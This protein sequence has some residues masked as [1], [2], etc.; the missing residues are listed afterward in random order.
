MANNASLPYMVTVLNH[1]KQGQFTTILTIY[2]DCQNMVSIVNYRNSRK[3]SQQKARYQ[4]TKIFN[5]LAL[6]F[7]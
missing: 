1:G 4:N 5:N 6:L 2:E 7:I 3:S